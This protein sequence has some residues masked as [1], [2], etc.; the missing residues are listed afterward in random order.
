[1]NSQSTKKTHTTKKGLKLKRISYQNFKNMIVS[2]ALTLIV[3]LTVTTSATFAEKQQGG[4]AANHWSTLGAANSHWN[5]SMRQ[6]VAC[7]DFGCLICS[8]ADGT[9]GASIDDLACD[10]GIPDVNGDGRD[11]EPDVIIVEP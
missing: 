7:W 11:D 6:A 5:I 2:V 9:D 10:G 4:S 1:M 8:V 3:G